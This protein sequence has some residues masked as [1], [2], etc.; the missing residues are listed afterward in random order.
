MLLFGVGLGGIGGPQRLYALDS[1]NPADNIIVLMYAYF[2]VFAF[3]YVG[4][5]AF[6]TCR[7][8]VGKVERV[9]PAVAIIA[10]SFGYGTVLSILED[11]A[12]PLF[13]GGAIA[14]LL[15]ETVWAK[16]KAVADNMKMG[17]FKAGIGLG[18]AGFGKPGPGGPGG[19]FGAAQAF[20]KT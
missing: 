13:M 16:P 12:I 15:K 6:L 2:G 10:F 19:G 17:N 18:G 4:L 3:I 8:V 7:P 14:V 1:F 5:T 20:K 9:I 11:Q